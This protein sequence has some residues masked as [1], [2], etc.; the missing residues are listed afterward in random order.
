MVWHFLIDGLFELIDG[1]FDH[2]QDLFPFQISRL[3]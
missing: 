1:L 2:E 3:N